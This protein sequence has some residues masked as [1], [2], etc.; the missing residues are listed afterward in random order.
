MVEIGL[1]V[2][3]NRTGNI[4]MQKVDLFRPVLIGLV[5][6]RSP[7]STSPISFQSYFTD[8]LFLSTTSP[9][10]NDPFGLRSL[11]L[12]SFFCVAR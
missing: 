8:Y 1:L 12:R 5:L 6:K 4:E 10:Q 11:F 7:I 3:R 9:V 2:R